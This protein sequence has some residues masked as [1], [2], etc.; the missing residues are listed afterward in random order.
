MDGVSTNYNIKTLNVMVHAHLPALVGGGG[1]SATSACGFHVSFS[2]PCPCHLCWWSCSSA[3]G[4]SAC[5]SPQHAS[6][7]MVQWGGAPSLL[8]RCSGMGSSVILC[9]SPFEEMS[10]SHPVTPSESWAVSHRAT[11]SS[12]AFSSWNSREMCS[13]CH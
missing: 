8:D 10:A 6:F 5:W 7:V 11:S 2:H 9:T 13:S 4:L 12:C 3:A 1:L